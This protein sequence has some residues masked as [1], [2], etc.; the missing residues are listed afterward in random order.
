MWAPNDQFSIRRIIY[1]GK[2]PDTKPS[3]IEQHNDENIVDEEEEEAEDNDLDEWKDGEENEKKEEEKEKNEEERL[4]EEQEDTSPP[5]VNSA[6]DAVIRANSAEI[7]K[8]QNFAINEVIVFDA[9]ESSDP[10]GDDLTYSWNFGDGSG[11]TKESQFHKFTEPG[12]YRVKLIVQD[13]HGSIDTTSRLITV[14]ILPEP[15][16]VVPWDA[17]RFAVGD[18]LYLFGAAKDRDGNYLKDEYLTW[19]VQQV[20][21]THY[22]PFLDPTPGNALR[23]PHA[24]APEDFLASTNSYLRVLLTARD[25]ATNLTATVTR[26]VMPKTRTLYFE[27]DPP[28]LELTLDGY[29]IKT[30]DNV[31]EVLEVVTWVRHSFS[32]D[33]RDQGEMVFDSWSDGTTERHSITKIED[34]S[35]GDAIK[36]NGKSIEIKTARFVESK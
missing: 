25:P 16:I 29:D 14:G 35:D 4:K 34:I 3:K 17:F 15:E 31:G 11:S 20:H 36:P 24:P 27:T 32:I 22:H 30:P 9:T 6:P 33:V 18:V 26:D 28:G 7:E 2:I 12:E 8:G 13:N 19:E 10:D 23:A 1:E 21:N 5:V